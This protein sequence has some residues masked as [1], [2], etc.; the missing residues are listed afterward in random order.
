MSEL[1]G[2]DFVAVAA[3]IRTRD[4][5]VAR[6]G[7]RCDHVPV[8]SLQWLLDCKRIAPAPVQARKGKA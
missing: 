4:G 2:K 3:E 6:A 8:E 7:E 5:V 1:R